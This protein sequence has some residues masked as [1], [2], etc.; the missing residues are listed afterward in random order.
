M[1]VFCG[2]TA[3]EVWRQAH[4]EMTAR[5]VDAKHQPSRAGDT[6]E[7]LHAVLEIK[8]PRQRWVT[9]RHPA[10]NPAFAIAEVLWI[11]AGSN[12]AQVLNYW[13]PALPK[14]QGEGPTYYGAYGYRLRKQFGIDQI[15]R[16]CDIL[17]ANPASRQVVLQLWDVRSD[18]PDADGNPRNPDI[19][20]NIFSMLKVRD[21]HLQWTQIMR[22]NDIYRGLPYNLLQFTFL[23]EI[24]AGWLGLD[25]GSY[26]HWSDS[27]HLY[28]KDVE[29]SCTQESKI[30]MN[31]DSLAI[32]NARGET[33]IADMY[34]RLVQLT[35]PISESELTDIASIPDAPSSYQNLLWVLGAESARR[36]S[37]YDQ[38]QALMKQ[39]T[40]PQLADVWSNWW[41]RVK[42]RR[43]LS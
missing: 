7:L 16:A 25:V 10:I 18:L 19:P 9:S 43:K 17:S 29:F 8:D 36:R 22:S 21:G 1:D 37:R 26:Y 24:L 11:L 2:L 23:Q 13:F 15:R 30:I 20:C 28:L 12:D 33:L 39:C 6:L 42:P 3:D 34:R 27:L 40:N 41:T 4:K 35:R 38:A 14:F 5:I 31:T 32:N